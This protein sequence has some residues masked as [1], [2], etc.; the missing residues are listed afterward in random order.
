[1]SLVLCVACAV[2]SGRAEE[3]VVSA[4]RDAEVLEAV[5]LDLLR[6]P[7][8]DSPLGDKDGPPKEIY[9][10]AELNQ[11]AKNVKEILL[12]TTERPWQSLSPP[13]LEKVEAAANDLVRRVTAKETLAD[14]QPKDSRIHLYDKEKPIVPHGTGPV[15]AWIP[16]YSPDGV[17]AVVRI[18]LPSYPHVVE[19]TY[20]LANVEGKWR[21]RLRQFSHYY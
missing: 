14:F 2:S 4:N 5:L 13:Q 9:F 17:W 8:H 21:V 12:R 15:R 1:M 11:G 6:D 10:E 3:P 18:S 16:G 20:A 7:G 19:A